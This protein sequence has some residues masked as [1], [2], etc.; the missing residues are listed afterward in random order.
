MKKVAVIQSNYIPWKGYFDIINDVDLFVFY[1]DVQYSKNDWR[2]RNKIKTNQGVR[3]LTIPVGKGI[4]RLIHEVSIDDHTWQKKH[5]DTIR[6]NYSK[7]PY[8]KNYEELIY[9]IYCT[10]EWRNLSDL[11]KLTIKE[12]CKLCKIKTEFTDS[13][14]YKITG[15]KQEK[16]INLLISANADIYVSGPAAKAYINEEDFIKKGIKIIWKDYSGYPEYPQ[17]FPPFEHNVSIL[18]LLL[19]TG[20]RAPYYIWGWRSD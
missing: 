17:L 1:D 8:Y 5:Y 4:H 13:S 2:N 7:S 15:E 11:N 6:F 10:N 16:L 14:E 18:D 12:I 20:E 19:N 9:D 3:W